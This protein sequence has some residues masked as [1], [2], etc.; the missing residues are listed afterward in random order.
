MTEI[1]SRLIASRQDREFLRKM[2][3]DSVE[4]CG[5]NAAT[6]LPTNPPALNR[7][8]PRSEAVITASKIQKGVIALGHKNINHAAKE[9]P[10]CAFVD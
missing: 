6:I 10:V 7:W 9:H 5:D 4:G 1:T 3:G 8:L 2:T